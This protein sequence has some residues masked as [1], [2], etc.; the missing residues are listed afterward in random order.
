MIPTIDER[1]AS[2]VRSLSEVIVPHLPEDA[3]L[4]REQAGLIIGHVQII[5]S[6]IDDAPAYEQAERDDAA[7]LGQALLAEFPADRYGAAA[8]D[9]LKQAIT[10]TTSDVRE[11]RRAINTA[12]EAVIQA[13]SAGT[14]AASKSRLSSIILD[15]EDT[16]TQKDRKWFAPFGFDTI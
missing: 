1:L 3:S 13:I 8:M 14:C 11:S 4:A 6:Q 16:R 9:A 10:L 2:I 15:F 7:A 5:R 12:I